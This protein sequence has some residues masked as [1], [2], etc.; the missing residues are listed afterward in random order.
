VGKAPKNGGLRASMRSLRAPLVARFWLIKDRLGSE[1]AARASSAR[2]PQKASAPELKRALTSGNNHTPLLGG[3][4][5]VVPVPVPIPD[6]KPSDWPFSIPCRS[7]GIAYEIR[8][9]IGNQLV[10]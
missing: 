10:A 1:G 5:D 8:A 6:E 4:L 9:N 2:R 3:P 7:W